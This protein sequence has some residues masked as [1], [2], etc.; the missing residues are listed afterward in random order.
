MKHLFSDRRNGE[1]V[2]INLVEGR[3]PKVKNIESAINAASVHPFN[4]TASIICSTIHAFYL[5][6]NSVR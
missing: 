2:C 3:T 6:V 5:Y 4:N 1:M